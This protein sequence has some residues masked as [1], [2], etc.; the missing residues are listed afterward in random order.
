MSVYEL[1]RN[2]WVIITAGP[3]KIKPIEGKVIEKNR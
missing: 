1:F 3:K 2:E